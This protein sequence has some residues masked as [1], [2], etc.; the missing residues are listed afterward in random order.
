MW[1]GDTLTRALSRLDARVVRR[2]EV[3]STTKKRAGSEWS[4]P[5]A[6]A[7]VSDASEHCGEG[8]IAAAA[9]E[10]DGAAREANAFAS[11][12]RPAT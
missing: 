1:N 2:K 10:E 11:M 8:A 4:R 9:E 3:S 7:R 12:A 6:A 5:S